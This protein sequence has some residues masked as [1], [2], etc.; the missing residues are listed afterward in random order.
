VEKLKGGG[1][2]QGRWKNSREV[3]KL[4]GGGKTQGSVLG[5]K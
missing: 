5:G 1:K 2:T 4:K 3:E